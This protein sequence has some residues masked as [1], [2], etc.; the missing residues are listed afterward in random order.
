MA[1]WG[2]IDPHYKLVVQGATRK[3]S[4]HLLHYSYANIDHQ[5]SKITPFSNDFVRHHIAQGKRPGFFDLT[6]RPC[7]RFVRAY[8]IR[9]GFLDGW[10][11]YYIACLT[12]FFTLTR[13]MKIMEEQQKGSK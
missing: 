2:G 8:F 7:W 4:A 11:G 12:V 6:V 10:A 1:R 5:I 9:L 13:Y 3:L